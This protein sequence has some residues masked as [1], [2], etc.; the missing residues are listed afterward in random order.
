MADALLPGFTITPATGPTPPIVL[1]SPH[2]GRDYPAAFLAQTRL[3][4]AQLR[5]AEDAFV[6]EMLVGAA[7]LG[8]PLIA[9][10]YGRA[11][12]D[13]NRDEAELDPAMFVDPLESHPAQ[14]SDRVIA[15][16]GV[17]PRIAAAGLEIYPARVR[18]AD[19]AA[20][21]EAVHRPYHAALSALLDD[22]FAANG[23]A[24][25]LDCHSMPTPPPVQGGAPQIV[26][27]DLFGAA[28]ASPLVGAIERYFRAAGFRVAR[29]APYAGGYTTARH[30]RPAEGVHAV[31]IEI[32]RALYMDPARLVRHT[33]FDR[34][35]TALTRLVAHLKAEVGTMDLGPFAIAAE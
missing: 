12:L 31:Q 10:R 28:A 18:S 15:G 21:I 6:A 34:I 24:V 8:V 7:A 27:G 3:T 19:A 2:S 35:E 17:V 9:A 25:L 30:G 11:W 33:E 13:L 29:N 26:I 14:S 5:R 4:L 22:A 23:F 1:A 16:L 20:R 32:D